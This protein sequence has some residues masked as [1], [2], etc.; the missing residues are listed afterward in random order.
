MA[1]PATPEQL[2]KL[3]PYIN[4]SRPDERG[5]IEFHCPL[6]G[7]SRR[8]ASLNPKKGLWFCHAGCGG[9]SIR[10]LVGAEDTWKPVQQGAHRRRQRAVAAR[11]VEAPFDS[12]DVERWHQRLLDDRAA[13]DTLFKRKGIKLETAVKAR[14]GYNGRYFKI[15]V[16]SPERDIWNVRTYDMKPTNGRRKI[17][18]VKGMGTA[19]LYPIGPI[20]RTVSHE[21]VLVCE[22][23]WD[24]LL[25][26]QAGYC[27][28]TRTDGAGKP[29]HEEWTELFKN[30]RVFICPDRDQ[31]GIRS[32]IATAEALAEVAQKVR[33]INLPFPVTKKDG[34]DLSDLLLGADREHWYVLGNLMA[35][36]DQKASGA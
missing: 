4:G 31:V 11:D 21:S 27:A 20:T 22:G 25:A 3:A 33:Y 6:H 32:A 15:P 19:R 26:L 30:R 8:S 24:T 28:V 1:P 7:D 35:E 2:E 34:K 14:I 16:F 36:A 29:W 9:G 18:S 12:G 5:E 13:I 23:E 17:W 10:Q